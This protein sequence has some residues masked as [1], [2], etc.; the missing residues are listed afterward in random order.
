MFQKEGKLM[1]ICLWRAREG[2]EGILKAAFQYLQGDN[3][4]SKAK[5]FPQMLGGRIDNSPK[6]NWGRFL[7]DIKKK[8][9]TM[10]IMKNWNRSPER[11]WDRSP[12]RFSGCDWRTLSNLLWFQCWPCFE[13]R[14]G[15]ETSHGSF[16]FSS[17][18]T[19]TVM[20]RNKK[21]AWNFS[22]ETK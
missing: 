6:L 1:Y 3:Q 17:S 20:V 14:V 7:L 9:I 18:V 10:N 2:V 13:E 12:W 16:Q 22:I 4:G 15:P 11:L 5:L 8:K 21:H 19:H